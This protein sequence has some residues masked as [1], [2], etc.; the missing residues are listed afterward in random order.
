MRGGGGG[1]LGTFDYF[2]SFTMRLIMIDLLTIEGKT[3]LGHCLQYH[4]CSTGCKQ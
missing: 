4:F 3:N 2:Q 1:G